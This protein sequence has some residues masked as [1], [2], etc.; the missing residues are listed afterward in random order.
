MNSALSRAIPFMKSRSQVP[1]ACKL[2]SFQMLEQTNIC[3]FAH[4]LS[5]MVSPVNHDL[6]WGINEFMH[7]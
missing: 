7:G 5:L 6:H 3:T 2:E 4:M 1:A